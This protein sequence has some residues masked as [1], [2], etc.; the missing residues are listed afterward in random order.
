MVRF[1]SNPGR[2][3]ERLGRCTDFLTIL[4]TVQSN[5]AT[6]Y[7]MFA[8]TNYVATLPIWNAS[9]LQNMAWK[10]NG[11][12]LLASNV[13]EDIRS[14]RRIQL[15]KKTENVNVG[16]V[17]C[18]GIKKST[19]QLILFLRQSRIANMA[20]SLRKRIRITIQPLLVEMGVVVESVGTVTDMKAQLKNDKRWL[21]NCIL[22]N[23]L[24]HIAS[25]AIVTRKSVG[26]FSIL[27][28][29]GV[30]SA[31]VTLSIA[32]MRSNAKML[33]PKLIASKV[34]ISQ[35]TGINLRAASSESFV[36]SAS[37]T[38]KRTFFQMEPLILGVE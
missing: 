3:Q 15:S 13:S 35:S 18:C 25:M 21:I 28:R 8:K 33:F 14:R 17:Y 22:L 7:I 30:V 5:W 12:G 34:M 19:E 29:F 26:L 2:M 32:R 27:E 23:L 31:S 36:E 38:R 11:Y 16:L 10:K 37:A 1:N 9:H 4:H 24:Q 6:N 20:M